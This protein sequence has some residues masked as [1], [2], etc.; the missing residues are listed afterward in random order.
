MDETSVAAKM[1]AVLQ[2]VSS[3]IGSVRSGKATTSLV[4]DIVVPA[5]GG[6]QRLKINE[7]ASI[8]ISDAQTIIIDPW[9]KSIIGDIRKGIESANVGFNPSIDGEI[10]RITLPL[11]TGEDR[12]RFVKLLAVKIE[13]GKITLRQIRG[14]AMRDIKLAFEKKV[15]TEDEK[16]RQEKVLQGI[17]DLNV[18][19]LDEMESKKK[20]DLLS[21]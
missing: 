15:I 6:T 14:D 18:G 9:D 12:A 7:L 21:L 5:Y 13:N 2:V 11:M 4:E 16:F 1:Q 20:A 8:T 10:I 19:K 3:D 17:T